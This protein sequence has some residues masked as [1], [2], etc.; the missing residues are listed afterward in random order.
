MEF[1]HIHLKVL[2]D[3]LEY[4]TSALSE[5]AALAQ[6]RAAGLLS[7]RG[8]AKDVPSPRAKTV[9][10]AAVEFAR[11]FVTP[12]AAKPGVLFSE[13][14]RPP[15]IT[16]KPLIHEAVAGESWLV[17]I[18]GDPRLVRRTVIEIGPKMVVLGR[19][20][21]KHALTYSRERYLS[22]GVRFVQQ[23]GVRTES[24]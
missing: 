15:A 23:V 10:D 18:G 17:S 20:S 19:R 2:L 13:V 7:R 6:L 12:D 3:H 24:A 8:W 16:H 21:N 5:R 9:I 22:E 11:L 14:H 1:K 4:D